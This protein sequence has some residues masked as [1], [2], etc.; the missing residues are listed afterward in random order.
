M[1]VDDDHP[2]ISVSRQCILLGLALEK[3]YC[4]ATL[5]ARNSLPA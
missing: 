3:L 5:D 4:P 2:E 1:L